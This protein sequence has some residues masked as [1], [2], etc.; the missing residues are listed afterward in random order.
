MGHYFQGDMLK[1]LILLQIGNGQTKMTAPAKSTW[2]ASE[3]S[4][5]CLQEYSWG[6]F[7][8]SRKDLNTAPSPK[9]HPIMAAGLQ[10][11]EA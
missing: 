1:H 8:K 3:F 5:D 6:V 9:A 4:W 11:V 7:Y 2:W 10:M